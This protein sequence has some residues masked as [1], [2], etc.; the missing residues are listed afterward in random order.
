LRRRRC[1]CCVL[2][3]LLAAESVAA[4]T[5]AQLLR[6]RAGSRRPA[7]ATERVPALTRACPTRGVAGA[8]ERIGFVR[9]ARG[10]A[11]LKA[12]HAG[13]T[14]RSLT[15]CGST[16]RPAG[17]VGAIAA[18][19]NDDGR[20]GKRL[21]VD[22]AAP[23][24]NPFATRLAVGY[25]RDI[26]RQAGSGLLGSVG[27]WLRENRRSTGTGTSAEATR[28]GE[29]AHGS[30]RWTFPRSI[31]RAVL[32]GS[33]RRW[34]SRLRR[35]GTRWR[36]VRGAGVRGDGSHGGVLRPGAVHRVFADGVLDLGLTWMPLARNHHAMGSRDRFEDAEHFFNLAFG[37][38][39]E[40]SA[41]FRPRWSRDLCSRARGAAGRRRS[42][43]PV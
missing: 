24:S 10:L 42:G 17:R 4:V 18:L 30:R 11:F 38:S 43:H 12:Q 34:T 6:R 15:A 31:R 28:A 41:R 13:L 25:L 20:F 39:A 27:P 40:L 37:G 26:P 35:C 36:A 14:P 21:E 5:I 19:P 7:G 16:G 22:I 33:R 9:R 23:E 3:G 8:H 29:L 2:F 1:S 32:R